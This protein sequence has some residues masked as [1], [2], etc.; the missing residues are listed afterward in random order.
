VHED[1]ELVND[2]SLGRTLRAVQAVPRGTLVIRE[3]PVVTTVPIER[4]DV[5]L[6]AQY[7]SVSFPQWWWAKCEKPSTGILRRDP[8]SIQRKETLERKASLGLLTTQEA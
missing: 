8:N 2:P 5:S 1:V 4:V 7:R 3:M 6:A